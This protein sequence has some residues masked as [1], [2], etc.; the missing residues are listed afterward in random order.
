MMVKNYLIVLMAS[1]PLAASSTTLFKSRY[2]AAADNFFHKRRKI[3][4]GGST[5]EP[6]LFFPA[7][8]SG[9]GSESDPD[10]IPDRFLRMQKGNRAKAKTAFEETVKWR[11]KNGINHIL[12]QAHTKFDVCKSMFPAYI[13]GRDV[14]GN[15]VVIQRLGMIDFS[16]SEKHNVTE[17]DILMHYI[18][19]MEYCWNILDKGPSWDGLM[20][21]IIDLEGISLSTFRDTQK[22]QFLLNFVK[23]LSEHYPQRSFKTL[24]INS[25]TWFNFV[26]RAIKPLLRE[27]TRERISILR[28]GSQQDQT[29]I[30]ALGINTVPRDLLFDTECIKDRDLESDAN[31]GMNSVIEKDLRLFCMERINDKD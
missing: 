29:L 17:T 19:M 22:R 2:L 12:S 27:S 21:T 14:S 11:E 18:Y 20:T 1:F 6:S 4:R 24:V 9:D 26:Y 15:L 10:G 23:T 5:S 28:K 8:K 7:S 31:L 3:P 13:A 25:P 16:M 30:D